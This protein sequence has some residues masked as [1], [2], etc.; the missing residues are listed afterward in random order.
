VGGVIGIGGLFWGMAL[1][2]GAGLVGVG[3][4]VRRGPD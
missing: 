4:A 2:L 3:R 1:L